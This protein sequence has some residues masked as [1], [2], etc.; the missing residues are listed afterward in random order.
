LPAETLER[1]AVTNNAENRS[2]LNRIL[3]MIFIHYSACIKGLPDKPG[4]PKVH[5]SAMQSALERKACDQPA[6][7]ETARFYIIRI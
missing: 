4:M 7:A 5:E 6:L 1:K 3:N 2:E